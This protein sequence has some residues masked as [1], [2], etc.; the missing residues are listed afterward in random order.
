MPAEVPVVPTKEQGAQQESQPKRGTSSS[1][2]TVITPQIPNNTIA[3]S[4]ANQTGTETNKNN[5][6]IDAPQ[7]V[8]QPT[9]TIQVQAQGSN[10]TAT[11]GTGPTTSRNQSP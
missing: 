8:A 3:T 4:N 9:P 7:V 11:G 1:L 6:N 10:V 5:A 2:I